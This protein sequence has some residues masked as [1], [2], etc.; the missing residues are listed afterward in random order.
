M[1]VRMLQHLLIKHIFICA[2]LLRVLFIDRCLSSRT[3]VRTINLPKSA[4]H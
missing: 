4:V 2:L 3:K 1:S